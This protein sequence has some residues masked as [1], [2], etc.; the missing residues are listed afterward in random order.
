[1]TLEIRTSAELVDLELE[2]RWTDRCRGSEAD[3]LRS[4][5]RAF[6]ERGG[7]VSV[8]AVESAFPDWPVGSVRDGW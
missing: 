1:M 5:L 2:A 8:S 4:I 7:P 3:V 6:I